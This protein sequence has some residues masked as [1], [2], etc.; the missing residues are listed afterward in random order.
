MA[1]LITYNLHALKYSYQKEDINGCILEGGSRSRKTWSILEFLID[2]CQN[3]DGKV[4]NIIKETFASFKTTLYDDFKRVFQIYG[5]SS[6]FEYAKEIKT[7]NLFGN[8]IHLLGVDKVSKTHGIGSDIFWI[9]E[10]LPISRQFFDQFEQRCRDFWIMDYNPSETV[11]WIFDNVEQ[12]KDVLLFVSTMFD[13]PYVSENEKRKLLSYEPTT[14]NIEQGTADD[15]MYKV[16][17]KGERCSPEGLIFKYVT[18]INEFPEDIDYWY[19]L[20]FGFTVDPTVLVKEGIKDNN[21]YLECLSYEPM[22]LSS[23]ID[24]YFINIGIEKHKPIIA[25][26]S[27]KYTGENKGTIEMVKDLK[28]KGWKIDKVSKTQSVIYWLGRMKEFKIHIINNAHAKKEQQ[29]YKYRTVNGIQINQPIDKFNH[30]WDAARYG[31]MGMDKDEFMLYT[32]E[33]YNNF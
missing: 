15:F 9:N 5:I 32:P 28:E 22:E 4:I 7:F 6:E 25:D 26:S 1:Q 13:N 24:E 2:Y 14:E 17:V 18:Y 30:F 10:A 12:R 19:G 20:D 27:D 33:T 11:H 23:I 31:L 3:N 8:T 21:I 29:S 16:Y